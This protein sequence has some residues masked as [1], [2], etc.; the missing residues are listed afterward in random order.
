LDTTQS[1]STSTPA[2]GSQRR[3]G[4]CLPWI[5]LLL[6]L[7]VGGA[8]TAFF[9]GTYLLRQKAVFEPEAAGADLLKRTLMVQ[10][11][12]TD[13]QMPTRFRDA[14]H[15]KQGKDLYEAECSMCHGQPGNQ[16]ASLG[17]QMFPPAVDL[18]RDRTQSKT[19]GELFWL[20]WHGVNYTGMPGWGND[21][22][23]GKD[24]SGPNDQE[25]IW[26]MV[27][28]ISSLK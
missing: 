20:I 24:N 22:G 4:S 8:V 14:A 6:V 3:G 26:S 11:E 21:N 28:Y 12:Y 16:V 13:W 27:Y 5:I 18:A 9:A 1:A 7:V 2:N 23:G 15:L 25:E 17:R 19:D 10:P